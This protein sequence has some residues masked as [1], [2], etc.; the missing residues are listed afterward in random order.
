MKRLSQIIL[1]IIAIAGPLGV[2]L[3]ETAPRIAF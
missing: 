1:R 3:I 2:L